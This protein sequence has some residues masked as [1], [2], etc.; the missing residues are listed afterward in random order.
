VSAEPASPAS[1]AAAVPG[2]IAFGVVNLV[3]TVAV[4]KRATAGVAGRSRLRPAEFVIAAAFWIGVFGGMAAL[5]GAGVSDRITEAASGAPPW[6]SI[7][8]GRPG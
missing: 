8:H 7:T 3:A 5:I 4:A 2:A 6:R 1:T